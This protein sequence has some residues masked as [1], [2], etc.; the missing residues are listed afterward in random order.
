MVYVN[1]MFKCY[2]YQIITLL[3]TKLYTLPFEYNNYMSGHISIDFPMQLC[4]HYSYY[5]Y[6]KNVHNYLHFNKSNIELLN[7]S[8]ADYVVN[9][10]N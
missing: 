8:I 6:I 7:L 3:F 9:Y 4:K 10:I 1:K 5:K 2:I